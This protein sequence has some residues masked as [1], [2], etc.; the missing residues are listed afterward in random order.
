MANREADKARDSATLWVAVLERGRLTHD[1]K[2]I[3]Q[4]TAELERLGVQVTFG[5]ESF[6][7]ARAPRRSDP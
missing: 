6:G 1:F 7:K 4:A 3:R 2:L 5:D